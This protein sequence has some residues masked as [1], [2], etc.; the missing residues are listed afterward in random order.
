MFSEV[1]SNVLK[2]L[3]LD[4]SIPTAKLSIKP[5]PEEDSSL[6]ARPYHRYLLDFRQKVLLKTMQIANPN[7]LDMVTQDLWTIEDHKS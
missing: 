1:E 2:A 3:R 6:Y 5:E 7:P 4:P